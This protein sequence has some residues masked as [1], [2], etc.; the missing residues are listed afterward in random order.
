M[1]RSKQKGT[2]FETAVTK[3]MKSYFPN[4]ER[5]AL[6]GAHDTG[7]I[8]GITIHGK[9][10]VVECKNTKTLNISEHMKEAIREAQ[11]A[12]A[13]FPVLVQHAP[14]IGF[15]KP[16]NTGQ[17][18]AILQLSD[19]MQLLYLADGN[20]SEAWTPQLFDSLKSVYLADGNDSQTGTTLDE[21]N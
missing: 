7:D 12:H 15:D 6:Q 19:F 10:V 1:N 20:D 2:T 5:R 13:A 21:R 16:D 8:A 3:Y 17:Q 9:P 18:W 4:V 11:N 14:R